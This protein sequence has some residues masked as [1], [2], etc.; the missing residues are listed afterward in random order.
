[1][2]RNVCQ[3]LRISF[4]FYLRKS[5]TLVIFQ[6][7]LTNIHKLLTIIE[8]DRRSAWLL[9]VCLQEWWLPTQYTPCCCCYK[10]QHTPQQEVPWKH[11]AIRSSLGSISCCE[12]GLTCQA[13]FCS[14]NRQGAI[15]VTLFFVLFLFLFLCA[16][17]ELSS[18]IAGSFSNP[19]FLFHDHIH[20]EDLLPKKHLLAIIPAAFRAWL[21]DLMTCLMLQL[22]EETV[23]NARSWVW[24]D[25][26]WSQ[27]QVTDVP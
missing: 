23:G 24:T 5:T 10:P 26:L 12:L 6:I 13:R 19:A 17:E 25:W 14:W 16:R 21:G 8:S 27:C 9:N 11:N 1:M 15:R 3:L 2:K 22:I 20:T 18:L 7:L 4:Y